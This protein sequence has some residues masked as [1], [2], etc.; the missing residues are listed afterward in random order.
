MK[1]RHR[2]RRRLFGLLGFEFLEC[3]CGFRYEQGLLFDPTG[4]IK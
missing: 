1:H 4:Y 2:F 3:R